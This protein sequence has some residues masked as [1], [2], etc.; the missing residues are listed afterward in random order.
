MMLRTLK[1]LKRLKSA[2]SLDSLK[3]QDAWTL[4]IPMEVSL[5]TLKTS[6][7]STANTS[8]SLSNDVE[9]GRTFPDD[10]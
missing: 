2:W 1:L 6:W 4:P 9:G 3:S 5:T 10:Y 8:R 7:D